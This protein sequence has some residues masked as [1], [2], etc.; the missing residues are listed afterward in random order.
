MSKLLDIPYVYFAKKPLKFGFNKA[1]AILK[2]EDSKEIAVIGDQ[3]MTD[4][5]GANRSGMYSIL[6]EP[7]NE[8]DIW[9]TKIN[10]MFERR[11]LKKY[12][13]TNEKKDWS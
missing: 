8:N 11:I 4:V 5:W 1:K 6:V 2:I 10:R 12:L 7:I 13:K 3:V 9:V